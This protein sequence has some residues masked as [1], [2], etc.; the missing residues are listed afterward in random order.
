M[1]SLP[2]PAGWTG[3]VGAS[4]A[5]EVTF[6]RTH[7]TSPDVRIVEYQGE[8]TDDEGIVADEDGV[9]LD[10]GGCNAGGSA[11]GWLVL[12]LVGF[13]GLVRRRR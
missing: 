8:A 7:A 10:D 1:Q 6:L 12:L 2:F 3:V 4:R 9:V 13:V 5:D 11:G